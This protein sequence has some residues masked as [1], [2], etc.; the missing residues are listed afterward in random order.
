M[1]MTQI[2][3]RAVFFVAIVLLFNSCVDDDLSF[4]DSR[5]T[6]IVS[7]VNV[8]SMF[9]TIKKANDSCF[10]FKY[11]ID[12]GY[13]SD[14]SIR[15]TDAQGMFDALASQSSNFNIVGIQYPIQIKF[16]AGN[17]FISVADEEDLVDV[18]AECE[19]PSLRRE[20]A[21]LSDQCFGFNYPIRLFT[22]DNKETAI[23]SFIEFKDFI[24]SQGDTYQPIF[25][26]PITVKQ[27]NSSQV[28]II[29][30]YFDLYQLLNTCTNCPDITFSSEQVVAPGKYKF[31][32]SIQD[33]RAMYTWSIDGMKVGDFESRMYQYDFLA[34][35]N[36]NEPGGQ[37]EYE[38][39]VKV[40]TP[41]CTTGTT[42][43]KRIA[44]RNPCPELLFS[45]DQEGQTTSYNFIADFEGKNDIVYSWLI[46]GVEKEQ[47]GGPEG[48]NRFFFQFDPGTYEVCIFT[49]TP[50][51]PAGVQFCK[52]LI[53]N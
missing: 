37:G 15:V 12:L 31:T 30:N 7:S 38:V 3:Y 51:C 26:F 43:C 45:I 8:I 47:D 46:D 5:A 21:G 4:P 2:T 28:V 44:V 52:E 9:N 19:I 33:E 49:E 32:P 36:G 25:V 48:N 24:A 34:N 23:N 11:P 35:I 53:V 14:A 40:V 18:L 10:T 1:S 13:N 50:D 6:N 22:I 27:D 17:E 29:Q 41:D 42:F 16:R 39:C 20:L